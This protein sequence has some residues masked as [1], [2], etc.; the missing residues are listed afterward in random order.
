MPT[1]KRGWYRAYFRLNSLEF[2]AKN[3]AEAKKLANQY[4]KEH[5]PGLSCRNVE[6]VAVRTRKK[7]S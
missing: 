5:F 1:E 2:K 7:I 3:L 4:G 6:P